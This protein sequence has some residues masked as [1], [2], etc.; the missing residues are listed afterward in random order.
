MSGTKKVDEKVDD[1]ID[2][3]L[4]KLDEYY[5]DSIYTDDYGATITHNN[6]FKDSIENLHKMIVENARHILD[7][8]KTLETIQLRVIS[9]TK[10]DKKGDG[11]NNE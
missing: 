5:L 2:D 10:N 3:L 6:S 4:D 9:L 8:Y 1:R 11:G 7:L